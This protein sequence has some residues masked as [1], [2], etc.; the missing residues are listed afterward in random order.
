[1][2]E[3]D[4]GREASVACIAVAVALDDNDELLANLRK[5]II[6]TRDYGR[7]PKECPLVTFVQDHRSAPF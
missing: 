6:C 1:M 3:F 2:N 4:G 7:V 5:I